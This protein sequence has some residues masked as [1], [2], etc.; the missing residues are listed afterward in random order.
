MVDD[1]NYNNIIILNWNKY[2]VYVSYTGFDL[3]GSARLY[4]SLYSGCMTTTGSLF[5]PVIIKITSCTDKNQSVS[6]FAKH[7]FWDIRNPPHPFRHELV[8][9]GLFLTLQLYQC[10]FLCQ[11]GKDMNKINVCV[12]LATARIYMFT[13]HNNNHISVNNL[14]NN[15]TL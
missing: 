1:K 10:W 5:L 14:L 2:S 13:R 9:I 3:T 4:S 6:K 15:Y 11:H 12:Y 7:S 8:I